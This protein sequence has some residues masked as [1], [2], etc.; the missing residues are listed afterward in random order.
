M[1]IFKEF[2]FEAAHFL[3]KA[4]EGHKCRRLHGHSF[5]VRLYVSG[6]PDS[7][8]WII[9][10]GTIRDAFKPLFEQ[11]DHAYLNDIAGLEN[12]TSELL[13]RWIWDRMKPTLPGLSGVELWETCTAGCLYRGN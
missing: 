11:L 6:E 3:P 12:P 7:N 1:E 8:G 5:K 2:T 4:P 10:F 13:A 9:D